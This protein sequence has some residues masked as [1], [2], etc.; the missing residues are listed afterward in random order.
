M[1]LYLRSGRVKTRYFCLFWV[2]P[3][4]FGYFLIEFSELLVKKF[5]TSIC[6]LA[7]LWNCVELKHIFRFFWMLTISTF[8]LFHALFS[9]LYENA[10]F[11]TVWWDWCLRPWHSIY[12]KKPTKVREIIII[13]SIMFHIVLDIV[14]IYKRVELA[15]NSLFF[16]SKFLCI[17]YYLIGSTYYPRFTCKNGPK[18]TRS[19]LVIRNSI[20]LQCI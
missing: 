4:W 10:Q 16:L 20:A 6:F 14:F 9:S 13:Q 8:S 7:W 5:L 19:A 18:T 1:C 3:K 2:N 15:W 11:H 12:K 17:S